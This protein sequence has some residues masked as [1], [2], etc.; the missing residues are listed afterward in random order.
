M[1]LEVSEIV[2][3]NFP[4][5]FIKVKEFQGQKKLILKLK[6]VQRLLSLV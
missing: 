4:A 6:D 2:V 5:E 1:V 3:A